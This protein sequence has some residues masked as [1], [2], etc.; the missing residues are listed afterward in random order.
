MIIL[1]DLDHTVI[2]SSHRQCTLP[3]GNLD[4]AH[5]KENCTPEKIAR[6]SV[7]PLAVKMRQTVVNNTQA[8]CTARV[9]SAADVRFLKL[10]N[11][12]YH[13]LMSRAPDD[14]RGDAEYKY[15]K[16]QA[17]AHAGSSGVG[18]RETTAHATAT[19]AAP[20]RSQRQHGGAE[21]SPRHRSLAWGTGRFRPPF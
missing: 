11:L 20:R 3:N 6:D 1:W 17:E 8:I 19:T 10:H 14:S 12:P 5:W 21:R 16:M 7:L 4:L 18:A 9:M 2:D 13:A 15:S